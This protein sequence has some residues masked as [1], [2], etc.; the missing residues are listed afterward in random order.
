MKKFFVNASLVL[1]VAMGVVACSAEDN[2]LDTTKNTVNTVNADKAKTAVVANEVAV[3]VNTA[4]LKG[5]WRIVKTIEYAKN[6]AIVKE[7][8]KSNGDCS[9]ET[10]NF[11]DNNKVVFNNYARVGNRCEAMD[12]YDGRWSVEGNTVIIKEDWRDTAAQRAA[13]KFSV[14]KLTADKL[15]LSYE[16]SQGDVTG[17]KTVKNATK[18]TFS[19][20]K[21]KR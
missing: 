20:E 2:Q 16:L 7:E 19:F 12:E 8:V 5:K 3:A 14:V 10:A 4:N 15:D 1:C 17:V 11:F 6:N 18:I 13:K 21:V 9:T